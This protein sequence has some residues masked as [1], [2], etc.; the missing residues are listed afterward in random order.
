VHLG[1]AGVELRRGRPAAHQ[2]QLQAV[3]VAGRGL[4]QGLERVRAVG[5]RR[6]ALEVDVGG[7][8]KALALFEGLELAKQALV[9]R[10]IW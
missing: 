8:G 4:Q 6:A 1:Q 7:C 5:A 2:A 10:N 9:L 3:H